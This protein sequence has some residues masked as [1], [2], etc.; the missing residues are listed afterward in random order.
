LELLALPL[1]VD[2]GFAVVVVVLVI[3]LPKEEEA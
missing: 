2:C 1:I 3:F